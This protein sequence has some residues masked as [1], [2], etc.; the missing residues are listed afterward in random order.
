MMD[1]ILD[2]YKRVNGIRNDIIIHCK[3]DTE[4]DRRLHKFMKVTR[5]H[6]LLLNKKNCEVKSKSI[7]FFGCVY[8][9]HGA[10]SD[11]SK[12]SAIK[13]M[14]ALQN[15]GKLQITNL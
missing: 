14:P 10:Q 12:S 11:P 2:N 9:K 1:Q 3:D 6:R 5:E 8:D 13:E 4:H 15:K 7:K